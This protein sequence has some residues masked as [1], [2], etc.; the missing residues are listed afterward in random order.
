M[1]IVCEVVLLENRKIRFVSLKGKMMNVN[2]KNMANGNFL[3][4][5][6]FFFIKHSMFINITLCFFLCS[7]L[8][9][10]SD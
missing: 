5:I 10:L 3:I 4:R 9:S 1:M 6:F 8:K 2:F 7:T